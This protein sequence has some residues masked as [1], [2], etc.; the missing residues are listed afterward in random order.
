MHAL[1]GNNVFFCETMELIH[2]T[3][4]INYHGQYYYI[5]DYILIS[6]DTKSPML[7]PKKSND[8]LQA[9]V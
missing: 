3:S 8:S 5:L 7:G 2:L 1:G 6:F 4:I 9:Y